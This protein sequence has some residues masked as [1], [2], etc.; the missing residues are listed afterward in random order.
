MR[1]RTQNTMRSGYNCCPLQSMYWLL[2]CVLIILSLFY[3]VY[4]LWGTGMS[5]ND[6]FVSNLIHHLNYAPP[7]P[8]AQKT[9][10]TTWRISTHGSGSRTCGFCYFYMS[11]TKVLTDLT[12]V[13]VSTFIAYPKNFTSHLASLLPYLVVIRRARQSYRFL[14]F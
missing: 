9:T 12:W 4:R 11:Y 2:L 8:L 6:I 14:A 3:T 10:E 5:W 13:W 1:V 7:T